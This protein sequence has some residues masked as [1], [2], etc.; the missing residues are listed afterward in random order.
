MGMMAS[1]VLLYSTKN[2]GIARFLGSFHNYKVYTVPVNVKLCS[3][4]SLSHKL[5]PE[6]ILNK[7]TKI[8]W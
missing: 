6:P 4:L 8:V 7:K 2:Q 5:I 3:L 1:K